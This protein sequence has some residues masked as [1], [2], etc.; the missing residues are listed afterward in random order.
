MY[1]P[2]GG[3]VIGGGTVGAGGLAITGLDTLA[4]IVA[5]MTLL[6]IG[7]V[8]LRAASVKVSSDATGRGRRGQ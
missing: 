5:G 7:A 8:L 2:G 1:D 6:L 4:W 3:V